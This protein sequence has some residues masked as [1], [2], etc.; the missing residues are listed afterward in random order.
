[1][2]IVNFSI[3]T[4]LNIKSKESFTCSIKNSKHSIHILGEIIGAILDDNIYDDVGV[5]NYLE[6]YIDDLNSIEKLFRNSIGSFYVIIKN[7]KKIH[8][9]CSYTSPGYYI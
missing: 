2:E 3:D 5:R 7:N 8:I 4:N 9:L 6:E 1:M